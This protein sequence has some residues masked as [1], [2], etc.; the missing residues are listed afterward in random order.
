MAITLATLD[1][2]SISS[3]CPAS[4]EQMKGSESVRFC[5][6]CEQP[7]YNLALI[8]KRE[9]G[10]LISQNTGRLCIR[11]YRRAD[12]KIMTKDCPRG[13]MKK[14]RR[15]IAGALALAAMAFCVLVWRTATSWHRRDSDRYSSR[16]REIEPYKTIINWL[17][18]PTG[19]DTMG[20]MCLP[21]PPT[22]TSPQNTC[23]E[24]QE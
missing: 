9:I 17:D 6:Q 7:V 16:M 11:L 15:V 21:P 3:P 12:G 24:T 23:I 4:W 20:A 10:K 13:R 18:P 5:S 2:L 14:I 19:T 1:S 8:S 22:A